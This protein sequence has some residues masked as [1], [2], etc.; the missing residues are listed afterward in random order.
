M[1]E[2]IELKP[3]PFCGSKAELYHD[4]SS[5]YPCN[6]T[7]AVQCT[8]RDNCWIQGGNFK[9]EQEAIAAWNKR[10]G[11]DAAYILGYD[12]CD[13]EWEKEFYPEG[14]TICEAVE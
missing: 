13:T 2:T 12:N 10:P 3:C 4:Q 1:S 11:E 5:D 6:W 8:D 9:T 7:Y 14:Q